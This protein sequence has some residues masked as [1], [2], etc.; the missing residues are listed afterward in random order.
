MIETLEDF[1]HNNFDLQKGDILEI[2]SI[3]LRKGTNSHAV[4]NI[5]VEF[6]DGELI[7]RYN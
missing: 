7:M 5:R 4:N 3:V 1:I 6:L 2:S